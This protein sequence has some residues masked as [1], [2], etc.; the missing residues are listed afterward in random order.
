MN[1]LD[2]KY[3]IEALRAV[4]ILLQGAN[5]NFQNI[6]DNYAAHLQHQYSE[7]NISLLSAINKFTYSSDLEDWQIEECLE[8]LIS[9]DPN[10]WPDP[11]DISTVSLDAVYEDFSHS[12]TENYE[13]FAEISEMEYGAKVA[14]MFKNAIESV[15]GSEVESIG[16]SNGKTPNKNNQFCRE[17][18]SFKGTFV[19]DKK[20]FQFELCKDDN[21]EWHL[22]YTLDQASQDKLFKPPAK[23]MKK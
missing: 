2:N 12:Y 5:G 14:R 4:D 7:G 9:V 10:D 13:D 16:T 19:H 23:K 22:A 3:K 1:S 11:E 21:N 8:T 6:P 18:D 15:F 20:K 17:K